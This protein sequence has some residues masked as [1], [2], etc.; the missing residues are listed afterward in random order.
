MV[1]WFLDDSGGALG[2]SGRHEQMPFSNTWYVYVMNNDD[3]IHQNVVCHGNE[4]EGTTPRNE[5]S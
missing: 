3:T 4:V 1:G 5:M 2:M